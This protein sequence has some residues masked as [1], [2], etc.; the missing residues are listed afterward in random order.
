MIDTTSSA[1]IISPHLD[2]AAISCG[3]V[4]LE[5]VRLGRRVTVATAFAGV[6]KPGLVT[7]LAE[8]IAAPME[9]IAW[10][11]ARQAE[12]RAALEPLG[13]ECCHGKLVDA[14]FRWNEG[15]RIACDPG[16][17]ALFAKRISPRDLELVHIVTRDLTKI[18]ENAQVDTIIAPL[19]CGGHVDHLI[20]RAAAEG[21]RV[22]GDK[23]VWF[24]EDLP[25]AVETHCLAPADVCP[26]SAPLAVPINLDAKRDLVSRYAVGLSAGGNT[27]SI[28][29]AVVRQGD[30]VA[31]EYGFVGERFWAL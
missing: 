19:G 23:A 1:L 11:E 5:M 20:T 15:A 26:A 17:D 29:D 7:Q 9:P 13:V 22:T 30:T 16:W 24:Y 6:P 27:Q 4:I 12:D 10:V 8:A 25:Y 3:G 28:V 31:R 14:V 18:A 21:L 2:D